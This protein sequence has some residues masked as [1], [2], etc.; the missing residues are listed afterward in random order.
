[1]AERQTSEKAVDA[2]MPE[3]TFLLVKGSDRCFMAQLDEEIGTGNLK[4]VQVRRSLHLLFA[5]THCWH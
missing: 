3:A 4:E 1:M 5:S 2:D